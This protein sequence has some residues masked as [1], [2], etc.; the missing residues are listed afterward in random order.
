MTKNEF[1][2][3][4]PDHGGIINEYQNE[5]INTQ[6]AKWSEMDLLAEFIEM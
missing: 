6:F 2:D 5:L 1:R 4:L 3:S